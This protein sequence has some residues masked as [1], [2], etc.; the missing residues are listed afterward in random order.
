M[1]EWWNYDPETGEAIAGTETEYVGSVVTIAA[2]A[3]L[4]ATPG[5]IPILGLQPATPEQSG[6]MS[7]AQC[8]KL[9]SIEEGATANAS[10]AWLLDRSH[11]T[12]V[13]SAQTLTGVVR[14]WWLPA[15]QAGDKVAPLWLPWS[16]TITKIVSIRDG[17]TSVLFSLRHGASFLGAGT[18]VVTGGV[19]CSQGGAGVETSAF[20]S[21]VVEAGSLI[22]LEIVAVTGPVANL[23]VAAQF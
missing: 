9:D 14:S 13:Q 17:G 15:P 18:E 19:L 7:A 11:H 10:D 22:W 5:A 4:V 3:P 12:G 21:P 6:S 20:D 1:P 2:E 16:R 23:L 8:A